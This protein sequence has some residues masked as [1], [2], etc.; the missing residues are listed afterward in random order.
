[1]TGDIIKTF[2]VGLGFDVDD[3]SLSKFNKAI[4]TAGVRVAA[5]YG[6][7]NAMS[8]AVVYGI[9]KISESFEDMGYEMRIISPMINKTLM[10]RQEL[11]K[12]YKAAGINITEVT[13][14]AV[15]L[16]FSIQKTKFALEAIYKS[17]GSR[18][19]TMLTKASDT[20]RK[21]L[22]DNMPKI[23]ATLEKFVR[24]LFKAF[25]A[26]TILGG[27]VW[28]I[29][30]RVYDFF[31]A[32]DKAT[33]GWSTII[34]GVIAA[35]QLLNLSF[36]ATPLGMLL[37]GFAALVA[38]WD[39]FKTFREGGESLFNWD[40]DKMKII[41]GTITVLGEAIGVI[42]VATKA[43]A[44]AQW[45]VNTAMV[46]FNAGMLPVIA[47]LAAI[48]AALGGLTY[49][50]YKMGWLGSVGDNLKDIGGGVMDYFGGGGK[51]KTSPVGAGAGANTNQN[52]QQQT[53]INV[54]GAADAQATGRAVSGE[55]SKVNFDMVRNLKPGTR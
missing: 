40:S 43:W 32:L 49:L 27:R 19:F 8:T 6:S 47:T 14:N 12:S 38:L 46:A 5:L 39:D 4:Q 37:A 55:Q 29:L 13:R 51:P 48:T 23:I 7:I 18:L 44:A 41:V 35:W 54:N 31:V 9:T 25:E 16:N 53:T 34:L 1:M 3:T 30:G 22:Y 2:L 33:S 26:V 42:V 45:I 17:A 21:K 50:A 52:V 15:K 36:L 11:L 20:F 10:L 28:S 24:I